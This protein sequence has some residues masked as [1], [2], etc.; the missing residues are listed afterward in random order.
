MDIQ[1]Q[2]GRGRRTQIA[3][4]L[5]GHRRFQFQPLLDQ[6]AIC[7]TLNYNSSN[8]RILHGCEILSCKC[9]NKPRL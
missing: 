2:L 7:R 8:V 9:N 4:S 5:L 6:I 1:M 3:A